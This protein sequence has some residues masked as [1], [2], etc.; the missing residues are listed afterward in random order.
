LHA[1]CVIRV[2]L[3][4]LLS[5][6]KDDP[7][8]GLAET[9]AV[10]RRWSQEGFHMQHYNELLAHLNCA[11]YSWRA[12]EAMKHLL[13]TWPKLERSLLLRTQALRVEAVHH[14]TKVCLAYLRDVGHDDTAASTL[15]RDIRALEREDVSWA[16]ACATLARALRYA[17]HGR[18]ELAIRA[19]ER[20]ERELRGA[21]MEL[22]ATAAQ[23]RRG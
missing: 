20:A 1:E 3:S 18:R 5:L 6:S 14:R 8:G 7:Q 21:D 16:S 23:F 4:T 10:M 13:A 19:L 15:D 17:I 12:D 22:L 9:E 2:R 11:L